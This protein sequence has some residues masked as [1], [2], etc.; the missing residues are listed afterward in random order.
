M[1]PVAGTAH[2]LVD[3]PGAAVVGRYGQAPV[4][5]GGMQV[6]EIPGGLP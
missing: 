5:V 3:R 2:G 6:F 1:L 4:A